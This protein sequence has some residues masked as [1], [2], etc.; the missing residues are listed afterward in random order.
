MKDLSQV[1]LSIVRGRC[2]CKEKLALIVF[3]VF[4]YIIQKKGEHFT[5]FF[6]FITQERKI[7]AVYCEIAKRKA[8][9]AFQHPFQNGGE[10]TVIDRIPAQRSVFN[11]V[12]AVLLQQTLPP[13]RVCRRIFG[14]NDACICAASLP[15][16]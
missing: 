5:E 3:G 14:K 13:G 16:S 8:F 9:T 10:I 7:I 4:N 15:A 6:P 2:K 1:V 12:D 11:A